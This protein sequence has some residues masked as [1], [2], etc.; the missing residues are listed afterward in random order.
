MFGLGDTLANFARYRQQF[1]GGSGTALPADGK[2]VEIPDFGTNPGNLILRRFV[3]DDLP[4]RAPLVVV[5]HGCTQ[6]AASYDAGAGWMQLAMLAG[7]AVLLPEQQ[8]ANN[9]NRCFN[10]FLP[11]DTRRDQGEVASIKQMVDRMVLDHGL[12]PKRVFVTGLSAGGAMTSALLACYPETFAAG[13]IIA[14]LPYGCAGNTQ[15][16]LMAMFQ[17]GARSGRELGDR[18]RSAS[19]HAGPWPRVS[20]WHGSADLSVKPSNAAE[21][22]KQWVDVH[23]AAAEPSVSDE[24]SGFPHQVWRLGGKAVVETYSI[25][26]MAHGTPIDAESCG[27]AGPY[28]L[29]V[30][31]SST[32]LTARSWG[33]LRRPAASFEV[34]PLIDKALRVV[35]LQREG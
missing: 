3:P 1:E 8:R 17:G 9:P 26:G 28:I 16:A 4:A 10:W 19:S 11:E 25:T 23:G 13:A 21:I 14:G 7:F 33:L 2:L 29:D 20:V 18:V 30:G 5:L 6:T 35:G 22:V 12:D 15:E 32:A 24:V 31:I 27:V 34:R